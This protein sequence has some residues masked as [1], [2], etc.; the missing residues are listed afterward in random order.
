VKLL[1]T[2][3][4]GFV[5]TALLCRFS[6]DSRFEIVAP[7]RKTDFDSGSN[8][9]FTKIDDIAPVT[10]WSDAL[11]GVDVVI[12][13]AARVHLMQDA[14]AD[15]LAEFRRVNVDGTVN[16]ARQAAAVGVQRFVFISSTKENGEITVTSRAYMAD[17]EPARSILTVCPRQRPNK[18]CALW[19]LRQVWSL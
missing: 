5:G 4:S 17:D 7:V 18:V 12:H 10:D 2:G 19:P 16:L 1:I 3:A 9:S 8:A 14:V 15:P 6:K 11:A 13:A